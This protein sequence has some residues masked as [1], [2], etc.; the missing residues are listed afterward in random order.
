MKKLIFLSFMVGIFLVGCAAP[1]KPMYYWHDYSDTLYEMKKTPGKESQEKH[2][3]TLNK[4]IDDSNANDVR[5]PPGIYC[6]LGYLCFKEGDKEKALKYF[7]LEKEIYPESEL[8]ISKLMKMAE[9]SE[10]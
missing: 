10:N 6:E 1:Q 8:M 5:V 9:S 2:L 3:A 7:E 4:I